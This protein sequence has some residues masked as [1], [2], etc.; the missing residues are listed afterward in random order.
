MEPDSS[1]DHQMSVAGGR[2]QGPMSE[3]GEPRGGRGQGAGTVRFNALW[4]M[5]I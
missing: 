4:V 2:Y 1:D 3:G 5:V